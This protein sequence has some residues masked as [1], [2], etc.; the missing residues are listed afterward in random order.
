M[1]RI[2]HVVV[3]DAPEIISNYTRHCEA[4]A[5]IPVLEEDLFAYLDKHSQLSAHM[6]KRSWMMGGGRMDITTDP[7]GFQKQG[8]R[9][10]LAGR[11]FGISIFL[12]EAVTLYHPP[13]SK[14]WETIS[15]PKLL[16][17]GEY[18][19]GF[20]IT[21]EQRGARLRVFIDYDLPPGTITRILGYLFGSFY[22][23]WCVRSMIRQAQA[24]FLPAS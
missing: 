10:C 13:N 12:E 22:A 20:G 2:T 21:P 16:V 15:T 19:M 6:T 7:G 4:E 1:L 9:L 17:I 14:I 3:S 18:R 8:S 23:R 24:R 5:S 11:A